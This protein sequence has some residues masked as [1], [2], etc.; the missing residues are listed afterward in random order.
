MS[1]FRV[2]TTNKGQPESLGSDVVAR[3]RPGED[4][5][6]VEGVGSGV[7]AERGLSFQSVSSSAEEPRRTRARAARVLCVLVLC[8]RPV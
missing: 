2:H 4:G 7:H 6:G 8:E 1:V 5:K 3:Q